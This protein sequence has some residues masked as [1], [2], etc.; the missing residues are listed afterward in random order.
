MI[1]VGASDSNGT[2]DLGDDAVA[3]FSSRGSASRGPDVIAPGVAIVSE[4]V[5]GGF[6][7]EA[8]PDARIDETGF[9]GS[10]TS[11]AAAAVSGAAAVLVGARPGLDPDDVKALL[12][13]GARPLANTDAS[14]QGAGV[15]DI[16]ASAAH[17]RAAQCPPA[18]PERPPRRLAARRASEP[19]RGREP[20]GLALEPWLALV[21]LRWSGSRWSSNRWSGSRWTGSRWSSNRW[22]SSSGQGS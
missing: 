12:R 17:A 2:A 6:L 16:A 3:A 19:V 5:A 14:L 20:Q 15:V 18:L 1:A 13:S 7:D 10:G 4:R 9:R 8:F 21:R 11:Q 22:S